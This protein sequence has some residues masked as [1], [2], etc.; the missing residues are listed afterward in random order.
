MPAAASAVYVLT[1]PTLGR[2]PSSGFASRKPG[3]PRRARS[4]VCAASTSSTTA[5]ALASAVCDVVQPRRAG[6]AA[7]PIVLHDTR[8]ASGP[9]PLGVSGCDGI[10]SSVAATARYCRRAPEASVNAARPLAACCAG[11]RCGK[12]ASEPTAS[13]TIATCRIC[14]V[15]YAQGECHAESLLGWL[16]LRHDQGGLQLL[17]W[18]S[19]VTL[20]LGARRGSR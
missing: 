10:A 15:A 13:S 8:A 7:T 20:P 6:S 2:G 4:R 16:A 1:W 11:A 19:R 17:K 18:G 9:T 14:V 5:K 12:A 3:H